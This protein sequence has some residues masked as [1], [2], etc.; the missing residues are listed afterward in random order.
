MK[1]EV[2]LDCR[3]LGRLTAFWS[4]VLGCDAP[5]PHAGGKYVTLAPAAGPVLTLQ[6][7]PEAKA[8]KNRMHL[9][10]LVSDPDAEAIRL[11]SLGARRLTPSFT[12]MYGQRWLILADPEGNEFCLAHGPGETG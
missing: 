4:A 11:E 1:V 2:T 10:L 5:P 7:V 9:D 3:D 6:Q 12:E 8:G